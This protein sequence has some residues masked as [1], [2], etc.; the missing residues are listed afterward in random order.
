MVE[1]GG[2][3]RGRFRNFLSVTNLLYNRLNDSKFQFLFGFI[4][5]SKKRVFFTRSGTDLA[6]AKGEVG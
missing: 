3:E 2:I 5:L 6:Q 4:C 1:V